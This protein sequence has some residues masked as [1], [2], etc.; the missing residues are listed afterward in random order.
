MI[1]KTRRSLKGI[2]DYWEERKRPLN[3]TVTPTALEG[4]ERIALSRDLSKSELVERIGRGLIPLGKEIESSD[5][6]QI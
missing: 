6:T 5:R 2:G 1:K 4:L 3:L